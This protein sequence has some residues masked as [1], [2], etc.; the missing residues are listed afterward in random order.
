MKPP[1]SGRPF[2]P[3]ISPSNISYHQPEEQQWLSSQQQL[4]QQ[5]QQQQQHQ[6]DA[7]V[8]GANPRTKSPTPNTSPIQPTSD[9]QKDTRVFGVKPR[10]NSPYMNGSR[11]TTA[12]S[13][14]S[15]TPSP[16]QERPQSDPKGSGSASPVQDIIQQNT[17]E[18]NQKQLFRPNSLQEKAILWSK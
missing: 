9:Q 4:Q 16:V 17:S 6:R 14:P 12:S 11:P 1:T 18:T 2:S 5:Q 7:R 10:G 13:G 3:T 15:P 8:F